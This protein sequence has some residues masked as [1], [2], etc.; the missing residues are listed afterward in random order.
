[1]DYANG[2]TAGVIKTST[3]YGLTMNYAGDG[4]IAIYP[5]DKATIDAKTGARAHTNPIV[6]ENQDYAWK[7]SAT[8]NKETWTDDDKAKA[9]ETIGATTKKYVDNL[10]DNLT[11]TDEQ[12]AKWK[13]WL[14]SILA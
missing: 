13:T 9:C 2:T 10:P 8:D 14:E 7:V 1:L 3:V 4:I 12:K 6:P 11:L 5:A